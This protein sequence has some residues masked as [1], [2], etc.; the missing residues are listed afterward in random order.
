MGTYTTPFRLFDFRTFAAFVRMA[1]EPEQI[2]NGGMFQRVKHLLN[3]AVDPRWQHI[4]CLSAI[5]IFPVSGGTY[6]K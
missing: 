6:T 4:A 1:T 3:G 2:P 5:A